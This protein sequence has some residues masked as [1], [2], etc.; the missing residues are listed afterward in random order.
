[1]KD[2]KHVIVINSAARKLAAA[3]EVHKLKVDKDQPF[4]VEIRAHRDSRS[5]KQRR[6]QFQWYRERGKQNGNGPKYEERFCKLEFGVPI[7]R[8]D[9]D[10]FNEFY[11][12]TLESLPWQQQLETM[13]FIPVTRFFTVKQNA[14]Y[15]NDIEQ[16]SAEH[17][18]V[19]THPDDL[20]WDALMK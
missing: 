7:L 18:W 19:L 12:R 16:H 14:E 13:R 20:Y 8:C 11:A 1:M 15:L 6:L 5:D 10:E 4:E 17:D 2:E 3:A 9:S